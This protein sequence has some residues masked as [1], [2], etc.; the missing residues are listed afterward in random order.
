MSVLGS[1]LFLW[2]ETFNH[3][4]NS[5]YVTLSLA[6]G[7]VPWDAFQKQAMVV[8]LTIAHIIEAAIVSTMRI[9][10]G[11]RAAPEAKDWNVH[12]DCRENCENIGNHKLGLI[13]F[14]VENGEDK[15]INDVSQRQ[16]DF[17]GF[18]L[19][20]LTAI[21]VDSCSLICSLILILDELTCI[22]ASWISR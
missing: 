11:M 2:P 9:K 10:P 16:A 22:L 6:W 12:D 21:F 4:Q 14:D 7:H 3:V 13:V 20:L 18:V 1:S 8:Q 17:V 5:L 19:G 15:Q